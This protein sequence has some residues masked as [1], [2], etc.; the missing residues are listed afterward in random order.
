[1]RTKIMIICWG[2]ILASSLLQAQE[3]VDL[4]IINERLIKI[5][6]KVEEGQKAINQRFD[7][8]N[9]RFDDVNRRID[10]LNDR[11]SDLMTWLQIMTA[12]L[13]MVFVGIFGTLLVGW[14]KIVTVEAKVGEAFR[15]EE[16]E[17]MQVIY[18][19]RL[20][21]VENQIK[22]IRELVAR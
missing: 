5:E 16:R 2:L 3:K 1:M 13:G 18:E 15:F 8:M 19:E 17:R 4:G 14:R 21:K 9:K 12:V 7:D 6:T 10:D 11:F 20:K 22:E